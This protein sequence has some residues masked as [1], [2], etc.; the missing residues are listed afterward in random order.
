[1]P[2]CFGFGCS[3]DTKKK[4]EGISFYRF[5]ATEALVK[6][7]V[8]NCGRDVGNV[9]SVA[10]LILDDPKGYI[11]RVC[12]QH[13]TE[14]CYK[15]DSKTEVIGLRMCKRLKG[16]AV[17]TKFV[18]RP[19]KATRSNRNESW[20]KKQVCKASVDTFCQTD[21][22]GDFQ[23]HSVTRDTGCQ[24][25]FINH[26]PPVETVPLH[27]DKLP[28]ALEDVSFS[29]TNEEWKMLTELEKDLYWEVMKENY[30]TMNSLGYQ[31]P[32]E[33]LL[34]L[35]EKAQEPLVLDG[36][37]AQ[38]VRKESHQQETSK[39]TLVGKKRRLFEEPE[40]SYIISEEPTLYLC[41]GEKQP[42][43]S[44]SPPL[45]KGKKTKIA[46]PH[47]SL[48]DE[49]LDLL[50]ESKS[51]P[52]TK[53]V[54]FWARQTFNGWCSQNQLNFDIKTAPAE[55]INSVLR[56]FYGE[57][58]NGT[59]AE[60]SVSSLFE[61]R[62][63]LNRY[64]NSPDVN[65]GLNIIS[66]PQFTSSN[67][68][69]VA[70]V[71]RCRKER[72]N[73][74]AHHPALSESDLIKLRHS[75]ALSPLTAAGLVRKVWVDI[76]LYLAKRGTEGLRD[77]KPNS[78]VIHIDENGLQYI[79]LKHTDESEN[80]KYF[81]EQNKLKVKGFIYE[82]PGDPLCP[83]QSFKKYIS[84]LPENAPA[85]FLH[86][87]RA[88]QIY[89][90]GSPVWYA[91]PMGINYLSGMMPRLSKEAG[92]SRVYTNHSLRTTTVRLLQSAGSQARDI[93]AVMGLLPNPSVWTCWPPLSQGA[94][95]WSNT[96]PQQ[97]TVTTTEQAS[98]ST[99]SNVIQSVPQEKFSG[100][101]FQLLNYS[102]PGQV[103]FI[104]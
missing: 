97:K 24:T 69:F 61:L 86:P 20:F 43:Q 29:F 45:K 17:P 37:I 14:D 64:I 98:T 94:Q 19:E 77:L 32:K 60:Y 21:D 11:F 56:K 79:S 9:D 103:K 16:N 40:G 47:L 5:P 101:P 22:R 68:V 44:L 89:F 65:R 12:S 100:L 67:N 49:Q 53:K 6:Q 42:P 31:I 59:G 90:G 58:R 35:F 54:M 85:L 48:T 88:S 50:E 71:K 87:I 39:I 83:V 18:Q 30:E 51:E 7:W 1:M 15:Q 104:F 76:Q 3:S 46:N 78:F 36:I 38:Q 25:D 95:K 34:S 52:S 26:L 82:L 70:V 33:H 55:E 62:A 4:E 13:F 23:H 99:T 10:Q 74:V 84:K 96:L 27:T 93:M 66:D 41:E 72:E 73:L 81:T 28:E 92:L 91:K 80:H 102:F 75:P 8:V 63:G 57:V 2:H